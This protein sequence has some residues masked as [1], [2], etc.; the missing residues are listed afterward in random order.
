MTPTVWA[1]LVLAALVAL[2]FFVLWL[3]A[4]ARAS[5]LASRLQ[6]AETELNEARAKLHEAAD[7]LARVRERLAGAEARLEAQANAKAWLEQA[8]QTLEDRFR[9]LA[10]ELLEARLKRLE[11]EGEKTLRQTVEPI[12]AEFARF[13]EQVERLEQ[14]MTARHAQ[15]AEQ[16]RHVVETGQKLGEEAERLV[17]ALKSDTR[18]QGA[19]GELVLERLLEAAGLREG[20]EYLKQPVVTTEDGKRFRPDV[21]VLLPKARAIVIDAKVSLVAYERF[22]NA[23][24]D[25]ERE[26]AARAHLASMRRHIEELAE[27]RYEQLVFDDGRGRAK[28]PEFTLM[29]VPIEGAYLAALEADRDLFMKA[30]AKHVVV[31]TPPTLYA[32]LQ[33]I[34]QAW[35][36]ERQTQ[37]T[38]RIVKMMAEMHDKAVRFLEAF[39]KVGKKLGEAQ[40]TFADARRHLVEGR[41]NLVR[42][43]ET[44]RAFVGEART[45][46]A[47]PQTL[48]DD[49]DE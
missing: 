36:A 9:G 16:I 26:E 31:C 23:A 45:R 33:L 6:D 4:R 17:R 25:E 12:K 5:A 38:E 2:V 21:V 46:R 10:H 34:S 47:L 30:F 40:D 20:E 43:L 35:R 7:E 19:W 37:E 27:R 22:V 44:L 41:G 49:A 18:A 1:A 3:Q 42:R 8:R 28:P 14:Q 48:V 13:A 32:A 11:T 15:L 39:E 24:T 29:F